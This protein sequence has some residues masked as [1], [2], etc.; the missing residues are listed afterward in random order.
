[1]NSVKPPLPTNDFTKSATRLH[2][3]LDNDAES[4]K[5]I[6][7]AKAPA[8]IGSSADQT[9]IN[10]SKKPKAFSMNPAMAKLMAN[11]EKKREKKH[12]KMV[13]KGEI[14]RSETAG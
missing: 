14:I 11:K 4:K 9:E 1:M 5:V 2:A 13:G 10:D 6:C 7:S 8:E 12:I 3:N